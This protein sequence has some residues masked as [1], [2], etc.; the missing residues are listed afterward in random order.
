VG[1]GNAGYRNGGYGNGGYGIGGY[2]IGGYGLGG[3]G[4]SVYGNYGYG[5]GGYGGSYLPFGG[6]FLPYGGANLP[7]VYSGG[8]QYSP[9]YQGYNSGYAPN[10]YNAQPYYAA[11]AAV[12]QFVRVTVLV[13]TA[14]TQVWFDNAATAQ[15]G[16]TRMFDSPALA[17][18]QD[19]VYT[20]KASWME[21]GKSVNQERRVDVHAGQNITVNF[22]DGSRDNVPV[23]L[24][25]ATKP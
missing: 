25:P 22:R 23:A 3:Y 11:P 16:M 12:Q 21:N 15:T 2:G 7:N 20:V 14:G 6:A 24:V 9:N 8:L 5:N 13:P 10:Y 1:R 17:A 4:N 18:N 19:F